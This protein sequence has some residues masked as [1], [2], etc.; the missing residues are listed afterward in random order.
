MSMTQAEQAKAAQIAAAADKFIAA[1]EGIRTQLNAAGVTVD[2]SVPFASYPSK[3]EEL[4]LLAQPTTT[5]C[6]V[7]CTLNPTGADYWLP[8]DAAQ[9]EAMLYGA[10]ATLHIEGNED[11]Y[12]VPVTSLTN[13]TARFKAYVTRKA[14][15]SVE[16]HFGARY[17]LATK[18]TF[19][20]APQTTVA[21]QT[22]T[23]KALV[24]TRLAF[25][26][27]QLFDGTA[28][29]A[30]TTY[31][32]ARYYNE[33]GTYT[34]RIGY[35]DDD[36]G[37]AFVSQTGIKL[38][39]WNKPDAS[40]AATEVVI[41]DGGGT[42]AVNL[43]DAMKCFRDNRV[44]NITASSVAQVMA[45]FPKVYTKREKTTISIPHR[46]GG[47]ETGTPT[48]VQCVIL[49][50]SDYLIDA[51]WH[52]HGAFIETRRGSEDVE[53]DEIGISRYKVNSNYNSVSGQA[54]LGTT[55]GNYRDNIKAKNSSETSWT[56]QFGI[57]HTLAANGSPRRWAM[58]GYREECLLQLYG[59]MW[60]GPDSQNGLH[61]NDGLRGICTTVAPDPGQ[62]NSGGTDFIV[63]AGIKVGATDNDSPRGLTTFLGIENPFSAQEGTMMGDV[64]AVA[65]RDANDVAVNTLIIALDRND[66]DPASDAY[67]NLISNGYHELRT[68][69]TNGETLYLS[70]MNRQA[71]LTAEIE[72]DLFFPTRTKTDENIT[73]GGVDTLW[74]NSVPASGTASTTKNFKM[75]ALG[76]FRTY[77]SG[78]GAF[79]LSAGYELG[80][81]FGGYW[82]SR[83][84]CHLVA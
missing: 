77:G 36:N 80:Y 51:T 15:A 34:E 78:L 67:D 55:R 69:Y 52:L 41:D 9:K 57:A 74:N 16:F 1:K 49:W 31:P 47:V 73:V 5:E 38:S 3:V 58:I 7:N 6:V 44:M 61:G 71:N 63:D 50:I 29:N 42:G 82:R 81:S 8:S 13:F 20:V 30:I 62:P 10:T 65:Y 40:T 14:A 60:F 39:L 12:T 28:A 19:S 45:M 24:E 22:L 46:S 21:A 4:A 75:V 33:D 2:S 26:R 72:R 66:Y 79:S 84:T 56:D 59:F 32:V 17:A 83:S 53:L 64:T 37:G 70:D 76:N 54:G 35:F 27:A 23:S 11:D 43:L 68:N 48:S 18:T 25:G